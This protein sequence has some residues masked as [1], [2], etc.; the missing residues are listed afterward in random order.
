MWRDEVCG[1]KAVLGNA[2]HMIGELTLFVFLCCPAV[3]QYAA[4]QDVSGFGGLWIYMGK[5]SPFQWNPVELLKVLAVI[6][7][8][9]V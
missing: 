2:G 1:I 5:N 9:H 4:V 3:G 8:S 6:T 7:D